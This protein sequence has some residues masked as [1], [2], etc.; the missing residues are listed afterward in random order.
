MN[1]YEYS[2]KDIKIRIGNFKNS[3]HI[4]KALQDITEL[5]ERATKKKPLKKLNIQVS[6]N[7]WTDYYCPS[8]GEIVKEDEC[9]ANNECRQKL[10]WE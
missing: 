6:G 7:N 8:C 9:C 4:G 10:E 3:D 2:L 5:V 1:K